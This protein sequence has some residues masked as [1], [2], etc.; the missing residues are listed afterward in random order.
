MMLPL[1]GAEAAWVSCLVLWLCWLGR[2]AWESRRHRSLLEGFRLRVH[3]NGTRGKSGVTRLIAAGLRAGGIRTFAKVTGT[4]ANFISPDGAERPVPRRG[5]ANV[6]EYLRMAEE[7]AACGA[8]AVVA[9]CMALRPELQ[10]F[11]EHRLMRSHI[12][13]ITNIRHDHE[14]V[15][16]PGLPAIAGALGRT[17]PAGGALV[18]TEAAAVL[19]EAAGRT[20]GAKVR[21]AAADDVAEAELAGFPFSVEAENVALALKVCELAGVDRDTALRGMQGSQ[22]DAGNLTVRSY[23]V[24]GRRI[25]LIDAMAANDPDS[26]R[27]LWQRHVGN[28]AGAAGVLLHSRP[29]RRPRTRQLSAMFAPMH[30]GLFFLTGDTAFAARCLREAGVA[31]DR[32]LPVGRPAL[33]EVLAAVTSVLPAPPGGEEAVVFAAGNRKG[34]GE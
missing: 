15:M 20:A 19:L 23:V 29:D 13:V 27:I 33:A 18:T 24:N 17:V 22:P 9:E 8:E 4:A 30:Q 21:T 14:E 5:P 7:A 25:R 11:C 28:G 6:R 34:F 3:V 26:T 32:L 16:G 31:P 2:L 12:G 10:T 1:R